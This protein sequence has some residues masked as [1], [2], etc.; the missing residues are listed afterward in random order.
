MREYAYG[1]QSLSALKRSLIE[2]GSA[3]SLNG[4]T[5]S[6]A[7]KESRRVFVFCLFFSFLF[8]FFLL[9][10]FLFLKYSS[11]DTCLLF[12]YL[13]LTRGHWPPEKLENQLFH[14]GQRHFHVRHHSQT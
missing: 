8:F 5:E 3:G 10:Y 1:G 4:E 14:E 6:G 12:N 7:A 13:E 11:N 9:L 2:T